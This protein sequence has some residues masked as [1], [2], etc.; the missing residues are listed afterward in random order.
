MD[1][2]EELAALRRLAELEAKAA[3]SAPEPIAES[4]PMSALEMGLRSSIFPSM[5]MGARQVIDA[6]AQLAARAAN[7]AG[8]APQSEVARVED[9]N[10]KALEQYKAN[11]DQGGGFGQAIGRGVGQALTLAPFMPAGAAQSALGAIAQGAGAGAAAGA[12][13]PVYD[14]PEGGSF[15]SEKAKQ[16][17]ASAALGGGLS[18]VGRLAAGVIMPKLQEGARA[19]L[20]KG[21]RLTPG[22]AKGGMVAGLEERAAGF[23]IVGDVINNAR[24]QSVADFNRVIYR[25]ALEP[26]GKEGRTVADAAKVGHEGIAKVGDFLSSQYD[27]ALARSTPAQVDD[28]FRAA[29][30]KIHTMVPKSM[31]DDFADIVNA[32]VEVTPANTITPSVMKAA[33]S[34]LGRRAAGFRSSGSEN[35]RQMGRAL[36]QVQSEL[37]DLMAK[38]NPETARQIQAANAGWRTLAQLETAGSRL[39]SKEGVVTPA[40]FLNAVKQS[41]KTVRDRAFARGDA[42]NQAFAEDAKRVLPQTVPDSGTAGR[43]AELLA[44]LNPVTAAKTGAVALPAM[45]LYAP[46]SS[47]AFRALLTQR[48]QGAEQA[49]EMLRATAPYLGLLGAVGA[50]R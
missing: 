45:A 28:A 46:G 6:G 9:V 43:M 1:D 49:A 31:R 10:R 15:L 29:V 17:G 4:S 37:R 7:A 2:R 14:V 48:P 18:G 24:R 36:A 13:S 21:V 23:P 22:Q 25:K 39:G 33:E 47:A 16:A 20:D 26:F 5:A 12:A 30:G 19:L 38:Y 40:T 27:D 42:F 34:E 3:G 32:A 8:I 35:E 11:F 41:D 50:S 44:L